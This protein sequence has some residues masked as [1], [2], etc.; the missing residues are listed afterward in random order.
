[1]SF[2]NIGTDGPPNHTLEVDGDVFVSNVEQGTATNY[3]PVEVKGNLRIRNKPA[4]G[5]DEYRV[6]DMQLNYPPLFGITAPSLDAGG[7]ITDFCIDGSGNVGIG[8]VPTEKLDVSENLYAT[9]SLT[10]ESNL[11]T[12][13][14]SSSDTITCNAIFHGVTSNIYGLL[15]SN[16]ILMTTLTS[17]PDGWTDITSQFTDKNVLLADNQSTLTTGGNDT[18]NIAPIQHSHATLSHSATHTHTGSTHGTSYDGDHNHNTNFGTITTSGVSGN[19]AHT[20][21]DLTVSYNIRWGLNNNWS[22]PFP[23]V[24]IMATGSSQE[25]FTTSDGS[26]SHDAKKEPYSSANGDPPEHSHSLNYAYQFNSSSDKGRNH[27]HVIPGAGD[28]NPVNIVPPY[29]TLRFIK[30]N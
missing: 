12:A 18:K 26:H 29:Y 14:L 21:E 20:V 6:T 25:T 10:N 5:I 28:N 24:N 4:T 23:Q 7:S 16:V 13:T 17:T 3:V 19:H 15:P 1:M 27:N 2:V 8:V 30:K 9:G 11:I 22:D